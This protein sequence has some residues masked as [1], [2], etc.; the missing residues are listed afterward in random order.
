MTRI[1][2]VCL[3]SVSMAA[4]G[5]GQGSSKVKPTVDATSAAV[6][7]K[8]AGAVELAR[9]TLAAHGGTRLSGI[10][11]LVIR[12]SVD[13]T[14]SA[15]TQAIPATFAMVFAGEKYRFD[16]MNPFQPIKQVFDGKNTSSTIQNGFEL[17]PINRQGF[18]MLSR[19]GDSTF[20]VTELA[21]SGKKKNGFRITSPEGFYTD[22]FVD[23][24]TGLIKS[25]EASYDVNGRL[26]TTSVE[27]SKYRNVEGVMVP[28]KFA[29]R[30]DLGQFTAYADFKAKDIL[31]NSA[32]SD[33]VFT[34]GN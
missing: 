28:E 32:V 26:L 21:A 5:A 34:L 29:Q 10:Q 13:I 25:Y 22:Y 1:L 12:G 14:T 9:S 17:P 27:I 11:T 23:E 30:F 19:A 3:M 7:A 18:F 20:K 24:K 4:A 6:T 8:P 16:L 33:D 15:I 2:A 31:V